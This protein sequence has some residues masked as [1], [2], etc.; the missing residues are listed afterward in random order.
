MTEFPR[1]GTRSMTRPLSRIIQLAASALFAS[2][3]VGCSSQT[4]EGAGTDTETQEASSELTTE[5]ASSATTSDGNPKSAEECIEELGEKSGP[6]LDPADF[7]QQG[8]ACGSEEF[9]DLFKPDT[10]SDI[11]E[12]LAFGAEA[13]ERFLTC[14]AEEFADLSDDDLV[15]LAGDFETVYDLSYH[16]SQ[17]IMTEC[18]TTVGDLNGLLA[19]EAL[20]AVVQQSEDPA[21]WERSGPIPGGLFDDSFAEHK[22]VLVRVAQSPTTDQAVMATIAFT[23]ADPYS[24]IASQ[25]LVTFFEVLGVEAPPPVVADALH[26]GTLPQTETIRFCRGFAD[27]N[28]FIL[29]VPTGMDCLEGLDAGQP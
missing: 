26:G 9:R 12:G 24:R 7:V 27:D 23:S 22:R 10:A 21:L 17:T 6:D 25:T 8:L 16:V 1:F 14:T 19:D 29:A 11:A 15:E 13:T 3:V 2:L 28:L 20:T 5:D 4:S 18:F